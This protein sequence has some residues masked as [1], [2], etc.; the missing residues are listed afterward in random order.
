VT[1]DFETSVTCYTY[2]TSLD[3]AQNT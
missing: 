3:S 2:T 1:N